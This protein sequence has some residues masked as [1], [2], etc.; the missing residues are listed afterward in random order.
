MYES[1]IL[2]KWTEGIKLASWHQVLLAD[3]H[4]LQSLYQV[5]ADS[6]EV[7]EKKKPNNLFI[8]SYLDITL[9]IYNFDILLDPASFSSHSLSLSSL[10]TLEGFSSS[11]T[12]VNNFTCEI[13]FLTD[14]VSFPCLFIPV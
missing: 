10:K 2:S 9:G 5:Y 4:K 6:E 7:L 3:I 1:I 8:F 13:H 11:R 12:I 14:F